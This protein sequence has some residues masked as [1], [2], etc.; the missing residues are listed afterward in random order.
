MTLEVLNAVLMNISRTAADVVFSRSQRH[1]HKDYFF[2]VSR[3]D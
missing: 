3:S 2:H 1:P